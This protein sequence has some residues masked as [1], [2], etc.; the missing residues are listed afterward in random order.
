MRTFEHLQQ[1]AVIHNRRGVGYFVTTDA[2]ERILDE[3]RQEFINEE[4][5]QIRQRMKLL[6]ISFDE[7]KGD[8]E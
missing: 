3:Q 5:P 2:K 7:L 1:H 8:E 6:G 4:L